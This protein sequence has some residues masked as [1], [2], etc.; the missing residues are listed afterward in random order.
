MWCI[1]SHP[2]RWHVTMTIE[3]LGGGMEKTF[4]PGAVTKSPTSWTPQV[5]LSQRGQV[6][7]TPFFLSAATTFSNRSSALR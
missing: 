4:E 1:A 7:L 5:V 3:T 2:Q 6:S